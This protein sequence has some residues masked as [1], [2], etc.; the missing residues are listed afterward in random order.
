MIVKQWRFDPCTC[1][2]NF[3]L[4]SQITT[5]NFKS[6]FSLGLQWFQFVL[7]IHYGFLL[8]LSIYLQ[9]LQSVFVFIALVVLSLV[10]FVPPNMNVYFALLLFSL[11]FVYKGNK[12][13]Y[14][15]LIEIYFSITRSLEF[16]YRNHLFWRISFLNVLPILCFIRCSPRKL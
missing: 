15:Y 6:H 16:R 13:Y 4:W 12:I 1:Y 11:N 5:C 7:R 9:G 8:R 10:Y 14:W 2:A 3:Y